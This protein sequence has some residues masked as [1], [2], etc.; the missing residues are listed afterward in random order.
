[1]IEVLKEKGYKR[2]LYTIYESK[3]DP[4]FIKSHGYLEW[5]NK[6]KEI[7]YWMKIA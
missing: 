5:P 4:S 7:F 3:F 2:I 6:E 1:M